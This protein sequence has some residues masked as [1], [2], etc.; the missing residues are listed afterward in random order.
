M[1]LLPSQKSIYSLSIYGW[2]SFELKFN[3]DVENGAPKFF[4]PNV[5]EILD[6]NT[7]SHKKIQLNYKNWFWKEKLIEQS[8]P[9]WANGT[10]YTGTNDGKAGGY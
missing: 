9:T 5:L 2:L 10:C 7:F 1:R 6:F 8:D 3:L 4:R